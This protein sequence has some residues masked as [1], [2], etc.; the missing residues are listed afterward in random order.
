MFEDDM[1]M[2]KAKACPLKEKCKRY[3]AGELKLLQACFVEMQYKDG[4]CEY[5]MDKFKKYI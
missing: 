2:C 5:F 1:C 4:I 3:T